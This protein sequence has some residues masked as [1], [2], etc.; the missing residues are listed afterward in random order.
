MLSVSR[1]H[2][3]EEQTFRMA[4]APRGVSL[5]FSPFRGLSGQRV[6]GDACA[7]WQEAGG[8]N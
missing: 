4:A 2:G 8:R 3:G 6:K 7:E 5:P 1:G